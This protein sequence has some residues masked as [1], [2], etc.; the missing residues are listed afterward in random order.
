MYMSTEKHIRA[1]VHTHTHNMHAHTRVHTHTHMHA[2]TH[3][4]IHSCT[5]THTHTHAHTHTHMHTQTQT[6]TCMHICM[7]TCM[8]IHMHTL[9]HTHAHTDTNAHMQTHTH[10]HIHTHTHTHAHA[11]ICIHIHTH[12]LTL[13]LLCHTLPHWLFSGACHTLSDFAGIAIVILFCFT[14]CLDFVIIIQILAFNKINA[15]L[16]CKFAAVQSRNKCDKSSRENPVGLSV[17]RLIFI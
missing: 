6:N 10:T 17:L 8:H 11:H 9:T 7:H 12:D 4:F 5:H 1:C 16:L 3:T 2:H 15:V 13:V 14:A